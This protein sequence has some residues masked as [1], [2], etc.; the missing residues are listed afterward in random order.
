[1]GEESQGPANY[2]LFSGVQVFK[3]IHLKLNCIFCL[4][5]RPP[6]R[7][8]RVVPTLECVVFP[9][10]D[11]QRHQQRLDHVNVRMVF[12]CISRDGH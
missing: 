8:T 3:V 7:N 9:A 12:A 5:T 6:I 2:L 11:H 1:M 10:D 4:V